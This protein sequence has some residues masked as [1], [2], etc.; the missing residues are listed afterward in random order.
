[1]T[2]QEKLNLKNTFLQQLQTFAATLNDF[3]STTDNQW[4]IKG[5]IDV[6]ETIYTIST[7]TK[8]VSKVLEIQ[9]FSRFLAFSEQFGYNLVLAEKQNWY[10]DIS[11]V[12]K[13][14]PE[15]KFAL[16]LKTTYRLD[17]NPEFCNGFTLGSHGMYFTKRTSSKNI[18]FPYGSYI[19]H[20]CLG[21]IYARNSV[22]NIDETRTYSIESI[23]N[24]PSV[25]SNFT[26]FACEKWAIASDKGGSG[27]TAN[28]GSIQKIEDI[29]NGNG[30]FKHLGEAWFDE[31]WMNFGKITYKDDAGIT[32]K[33]TSLKD[34]IK[35]KGGDE[36]LINPK[37]A[38]KG[39]KNGR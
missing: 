15:I 34:F 38:R 24:I 16:D 35:F 12:S 6:F 5:F 27:N 2:E 4:S 30:I 26:F 39:G 13:I 9:L 37:S 1:M 7:D 28:I 3:V 17:E 32:K 21:I 33:I 14:N 20:Y 11:F 18:Q 31:Y 8:I 22:K 23:K 36:R 29:L 19:G 10:P 25:I